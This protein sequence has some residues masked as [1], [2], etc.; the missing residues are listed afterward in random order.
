M[1]RTITFHLMFFRIGLFFLPAA[2][3]E[4]ISDILFYDTLLFLI[5]EVFQC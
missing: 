4:H 1:F 2:L 5:W 3:K